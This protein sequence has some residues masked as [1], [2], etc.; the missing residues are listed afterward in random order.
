MKVIDTNRHK[1]LAPIILRK[2]PCNSSGGAKP[3][4]TCAL[5]PGG[6]LG[7]FAPQESPLITRALPPQRPCLALGGR[8]PPYL[9]LAP[10]GGSGGLRSV[11]KLRYPCLASAAAVPCPPFFFVQIFSSEFFRPNFFR[12]SSV[13][14]PSVRRP[15]VRRPSVV[16]PSS[17][18]PSS[19]GC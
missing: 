5:P 19:D 3:P 13:R 18:S 12:P 1:T 9:C 10:R 8:S 16:R 7:G 14:R 4:H 11:R 6:G 2:I 17:S 15:F